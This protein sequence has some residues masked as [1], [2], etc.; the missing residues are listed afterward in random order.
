ME[1]REAQSDRALIER[2]LRRE[3]EACRALVARLTP[4]IQSRVNAALIRRGRAQR[5]EVLDLTQEVFRIL[6]DQ[7]GRILRAFDPARGATLPGYVAMVAERRIASLL[8]SGRQSG[9]AEDPLSPE[10]MD[11]HDDPS[12]SPEGVAISRDLLVRVLDELRAGVSDRGYE[13]FHWLYVEERE[14]EWVMAQ[15]G[16]SRD[17]VYAWRSRLQKVIRQVAARLASDPAPTPRS[18]AEVGP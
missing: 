16:L 2:A 5:Q 17:A 11:L 6:L 13:M 4:A 15:S 18:K 8:R 9:W 7:D 3:P 14:V 10:V 12:P 1:V